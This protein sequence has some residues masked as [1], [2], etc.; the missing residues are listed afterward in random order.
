MTFSTI[1]AAG[2]ADV[3]AANEQVVPFVSLNP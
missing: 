1:C 2:C 3:P